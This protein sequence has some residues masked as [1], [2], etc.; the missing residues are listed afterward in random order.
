MQVDYVPVLVAQDLHFDVLRAR[1][2]FLQEHR[3]VPKRPAGL[4]LRLVQQARQVGRLVDHPHAA[5]A[6]AKRGLDDERKADAPRD[7]QGFLPPGYRLL[8]PVERR[9]PQ[10][11]RQGPRG[12]FVPHHLQQL[13]PG[14]HK[15]YP[16]SR[17]RPRKLRI[18]AQKAV[19]GM[20]R[21]DPGRFGQ[22]DD[23][24]YIQVGRHGPLALPDQVGLVGFKAV[25]AEAVFL[26]VNGHGA[27]P[28]VGGRPEDAD[29]DL[30][31][32]GRQKLGEPPR[33]RWRR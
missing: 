27:Q 3:R 13:G 6:A 25:D 16:R 9:H 26:G 7:L 23:A 33:G 17:A 19:A 22:G 4:G 8:G 20:D 30:G 32:I 12:D 2:V 15:G 18:L 14:A 28:Q 21:L 10:A 11:L 31:A 1:D 24:V 29:G 5:A